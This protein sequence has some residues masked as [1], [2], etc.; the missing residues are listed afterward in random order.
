MNLELPR[1]IFSKYSNTKFHKNTSS[2]ILAIFRADRQTDMTT[3]I[4]TFRN[5]EKAPN[6]EVMYI[7]CKRGPFGKVY[8]GLQKFYLPHLK[9]LRQAEYNRLPL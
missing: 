7:A 1:W 9:V 5:F 8:V 3:L 2:E 6:N 4:V